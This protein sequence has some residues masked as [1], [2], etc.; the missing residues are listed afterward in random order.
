M[1]PNRTEPL[2]DLT[3][4][5]A[6]AVVFAAYMLGVFLDPMS[7]ATVGA[8]VVAGLAVVLAPRG[9]R[10]APAV[11]GVAGVLLAG[12]VVPWAVFEGLVVDAGASTEPYLAALGS[13]AVLASLFAVLRVTARPGSRSAPP[14]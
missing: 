3:V 12:Y 11:V 2:F 14:V 10:V 8:A 9:A 13:L 1:S 6:S 5:L 4:T 7:A